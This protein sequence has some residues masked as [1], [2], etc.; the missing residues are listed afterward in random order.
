MMCFFFAQQSKA[1]RQT[2]A[3]V[4]LR[5]SIECFPSG[6]GRAS[7]SIYIG[8]GRVR[9]VIRGY[10]RVR[11]CKIRPVYWFLVMSEKE[12]GEE[13][14]ALSVWSP[15]VPRL[16]IDVKDQNRQRT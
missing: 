10:G 15:D 7:V 1:P 8:S 9:N 3:S 5:R 6:A 13:T 4:I 12:L 16:Q 11:V 14:L 2:P